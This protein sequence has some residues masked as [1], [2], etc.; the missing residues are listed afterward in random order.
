LTGLYMVVGGTLAV[1]Y[2]PI[3]VNI[4]HSFFAGIAALLLWPLTPEKS[5]NVNNSFIIVAVLYCGIIATALAFTFML[6]AQKH[7][8]ATK[9]SVLCAT[10]PVFAVLFAMIIPDLTGKTETLKPLIVIGG[11]FILSGVL[12]SV[13]RHARVCVNKR[14]EE[15]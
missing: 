14:G 2:D 4:I 9:T 3:L 8:D 10:E 6:K 13:F 7:I 15:G 11:A 12:T 1:R 5:F